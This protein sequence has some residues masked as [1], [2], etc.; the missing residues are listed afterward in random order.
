MQKYFLVTKV[1][2]ITFLIQNDN[3]GFIYQNP[4]NYIH[5]AHLLN[6]IYILPIN[7]NHISGFC[8]NKQKI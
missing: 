3:F 6:Y 7:N 5:Q 2:I 4:S 1:A 8:W